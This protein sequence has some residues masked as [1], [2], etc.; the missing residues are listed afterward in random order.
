VP[1]ARKCDRGLAAVGHRDVAGAQLRDPGQ[2]L[3]VEQQHA[4]GE[5]LAQAELVVVEQ[6]T[7]N[8]EALLILQRW[9]PREVISPIDMQRAGDV[10]ALQPGGE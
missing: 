8:G 1:A 2:W 6:P 5:S 4:A 9:S 7:Q 10:G 3:G